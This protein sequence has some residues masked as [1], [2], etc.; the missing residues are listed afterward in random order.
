MTTVGGT[1]RD[2]PI[3]V[4]RNLNPRCLLGMDVLEC[5]GS[6]VSIELQKKVATVRRCRLLADA[7]RVKMSH[8]VCITAKHEAVLLCCVPNRVAV[9]SH[10][11]GAGSPHG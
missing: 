1:V 5:L 4:V 7:G 2:N 11:S 6:H 10:F 8:S 3:Y 9:G